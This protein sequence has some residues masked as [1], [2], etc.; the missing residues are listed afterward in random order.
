MKC[1]T[2]CRQHVDRLWSTVEFFAGNGAYTGLD[3]CLSCS[4]VVAAVIELVPGEVPMQTLFPFSVPLN[5]PEDID[6]A[7]HHSQCRCDDCD[8]DFRFEW[9]REERT[10]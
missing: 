1:C 7:E 9:Q 6:D 3:L 8:P 2:R 5:D 4:R 10:A